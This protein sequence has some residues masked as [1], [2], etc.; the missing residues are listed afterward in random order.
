MTLRGGNMEVGI[1]RKGGVE[2]AHGLQQHCD[3]IQIDQTFLHDAC[4][5][6]RDAICLYHVD[7]YNND[8]ILLLVDTDDTAISLTQPKDSLFILE[9]MVQT[10]F[11]PSRMF[12]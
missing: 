9:H 8:D 3:S 2:R 4:S 5:A 12:R 11:L 10:D 6:A 7:A 1:E